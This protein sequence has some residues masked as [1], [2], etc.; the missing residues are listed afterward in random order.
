MVMP[1]D[2]EVPAKAQDMVDIWEYVAED[3]PAGRVPAGNR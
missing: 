3:D 2:D 1:I